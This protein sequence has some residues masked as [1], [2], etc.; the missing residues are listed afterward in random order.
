MICNYTYTVTLEVK[1]EW[2]PWILYLL[3]GSQD[4][5]VVNYNWFY[6]DEK[7]N[8]G[9]WLLGFEDLTYLVKI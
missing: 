6:P 8:Q 1:E 2:N 4:T 9:M 7:L 3:L 5:F